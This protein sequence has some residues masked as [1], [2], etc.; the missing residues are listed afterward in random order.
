MKK[1][2]KFVLFQP[3][4]PGNIGAAARAISTMGF[5]K[6]ALVQP[7]MKH[8]QPESRARSSGALDVLVNAE[9]FPN[10]QEA[11]SDCGFIVGTTI[12]G[13]RISVPTSTVREFATEI[14]EKANQQNI[15]IIFGPEKTGLTN[16]EIDC[17]NHL[18]EI[19]SSK[20]Y[21]SLNLAAAVQVIAYELRIN[22][23]TIK[24]KTI[25]R[26]LASN[27]EMELFY[28]HLNDVLLETGFL[29]P[30]NPRQLMRRLRVLFNRA[31][32]DENEMNIMRGILASFQSTSNKKP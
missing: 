1:N 10:L 28:S 8:P 16:S 5:T 18:I 14:N 13:R 3:S 26:D 25:D 15:T 24:E 19:P 23:M 9:V 12:R 29:N 21:S 31:E 30:R 2:I 17:C 22:D 6:L 11:I 20:K 4:H 27:E 7:S 32:M